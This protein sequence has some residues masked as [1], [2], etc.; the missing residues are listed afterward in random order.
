MEPLGLLAALLEP[1]SE[2]SSRTWWGGLAFTGLIALGYWAGVRP[3]TWTRRTLADGLLHP[4]TGLDLQLYLGRQLLRLL[5][6]TPSLI[7]GWAL[8]THG[9]RWLDGAIGPP[10]ALGWPGWVGS[11]VYT[12]ALFI[13]WDASR[14]VLHWLGHRVPF[15]WAFHQVHHSAEVLTPLT[16]HRIHPVE[17]WLYD[18]RGALVTGVVAGGFYWLFR[19]EVSHWTLLGV[20]AMGLVL[21]VVTGN[22]RHTHVWIRFPRGVE[23]WLLS[24]A[25]HQIHHGMEPGECHSNMGTWLAIW[26]RLAGTLVTAEERPERYGLPTAELNH[27]NN[28][29]SAWFGPFRA[30][31]PLVLVCVL[32]APVPV[33]QAGEAEEEGAEGAEVE[34]EEVEEAPPRF[35]ESI[36]VYRNDALQM[37]GSAHVVGEEELVLQDYDDIERVLQRVPGISTRGEDGFGL[38]PNIGIRGAN[39][40]RSAK[41]TLLEDGVLLAPAPYAAPAAYYF[42]MSTRLVGVEVFKGAASTLHGPQ[43]VGGAINVLTRPVPEGPGA[44]GDVSVG[45]RQSVKAHAWAATRQERAGVLVEG[46]HLRSDGFKELDGGGPT[47]F[48]RS[49]VMAKGE[50]LPGGSHLCEWKLGFAN[51][52]SHETYLGLTEGD[53]SET[54]YRRYAASQL[55]L[56]E[57]NRG[58]VELAWVVRPGTGVT[59]RTVAYGHTLDRAWT[60]LGGFSDGTNL[61]NLL[62]VAPDSGQGAVLLAILR[63]EEDTAGTFLQIG[64][65]DRK[66][67]SFG[68]QSRA[69]WE[70][71]GPRVSSV[72]ETGVRLHGDDVTRLHTE[73]SYDMRSGE[74]VAADTGGEETLLDSEATARAL[75]VHVHEDLRIDRVHVFPSARVEVV[76]GDRVD[77]GVE[78]NPALTR[79]T[80]LPGFGVLFN[81]GEW[82]DLFAGSHRGF[83]PVAPGQPAEVE[84]ELS[85]NHEAGL[86]L[87][88]G[89]LHGSLAGFLNDYQNLTG[90]C[91]FS[92]GC[93]GDSV[94]QQFNGGEVLIFG[95]EATAGHRLLLE[96]GLEFPVDATYAWTRSEFQTGFSS[97]FPQFGTVEAG[98]SLP[99]VAKHQGAL[100]AGVA[101]DGVSLGAGISYR[102]EMLD[103]AGQF[104]EGD[105]I[106]ALW[107][108][109]AA[110]SVA[111]ARGWS[112]TATGTNLAG[113]TGIT[114]WRPFG[115]RPTAPSQVMVGLKWEGEPLG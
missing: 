109:D 84:P 27:G 96:S 114:S 51:E 53:W 50:W 6:G 28:L 110:A 102:G 106:A 76:Y 4:S 1:F 79:T 89:D 14:F 12:L 82:T 5:V 92:G 46:V 22:L 59:V 17:S 66:F 101:T 88:L 8:A 77:V 43:T 103:A 34:T 97:A 37:A 49:E 25:Q 63:G 18:L 105:E 48:D 81:A 73:S 24:P 36:I 85:W 40:D 113:A 67:E 31:V 39:S 35:G 78:P 108:V 65:N 45:L 87:D 64:T 26:D 58:Q 44:Y 56:M 41:V 11:V 112:A 90:E 20:P 86:R 107:L 19:G 60:K 21:N 30:L 100:H 93:T 10:P 38:R 16:F 115:A 62:R 57:W 61:H 94:G 2:P 55:G 3:P 91:T 15:L 75:A 104:G 80:V 54:P 23:H 42:P 32:A 47:G 71:H 99:Y 9:V 95:L 33:A 111:L 13:A 52:T 74:V 29:L 98:D 83:S 70:V 69:R 7:T 68:V 72:L